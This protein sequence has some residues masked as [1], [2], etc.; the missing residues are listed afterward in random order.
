MLT[1]ATAV[2]DSLPANKKDAFYEMVLY[3]LRASQLQNQKYIAAG[4][5]DLYARQGRTASVT[6]YRNLSTTAYEHHRQRF[7][8]VH[9]R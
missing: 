6:K 7:V 4:K 3:P 9:D 2:S 8:L 1:R 5:A